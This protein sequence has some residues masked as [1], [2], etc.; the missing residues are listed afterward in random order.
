MRDSE[1]QLEPQTPSQSPQV[2]G[3]PP[4]AVL[5]EEF[6]FLDKLIQRLPGW[7]MPA[8]SRALITLPRPGRQVE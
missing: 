2:G 1:I 8:Q 6:Y 5:E 3:H 7:G 4:P